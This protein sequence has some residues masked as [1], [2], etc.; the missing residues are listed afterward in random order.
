DH[1]PGVCALERFGTR[2][3]FVARALDEALKPKR[4]RQQ[5]SIDGAVID[6][7]PGRPV[8]IFGRPAR[9]QDP[10]E[11]ALG[12]PR[13]ADIQLDDAHEAIGCATYE[14]VGHPIS[15]AIETLRG[16]LCLDVVAA[17]D[18]HG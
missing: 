6:Q 5:G 4:A 18:E 14:G 11:M 1:E 9:L 17:K 7:I 8:A 3:R 15:D 13:L 10:L 16:D 2:L 12:L